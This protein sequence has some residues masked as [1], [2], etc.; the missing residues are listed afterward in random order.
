[1]SADD[2]VA[3]RPPGRLIASGRAAD[4]FDLGD[5]T[6]LRRYRSEHDTAPEG[7]LMRW[8]ATSGVPVPAVHRADGR[9]L[10]MDHV[11]GPTM[12]EDLQRRPWRLRRH[13]RT[14]ADL[15]R[16]INDVTAPDWLAAAQAAP[17]GDGIVHG[18][19]HPMNVILGAS[20][21]VVI[22]FTNAGRGPA[23]F[24]SALSYVLMSTFEARAMT[25][26]IGQRLLVG[27]FR[28]ARGSDLVAAGVADACRFRL[29]DAN[30]TPAERD[31]VEHLYARM[32]SGTAVSLL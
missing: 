13:A 5:G 20:G 7:R 31:R 16:S 3:E 25:D 18:D 15:Q 29:A 17:G 32:T 28:R 12:L 24:D 11:G 2:G 27:A 14:L 6:V 10:V 30:V 21:P 23:S 1:M 22:D 9:E 26:R 8:L 4:V 19:L